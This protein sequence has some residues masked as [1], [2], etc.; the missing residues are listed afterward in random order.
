M[1]S[2]IKWFSTYLNN[3]PGRILILVVQ[4]TL[5]WPLYLMFNV[6]GRPYDRFACH[7]DPNSPIYTDHECLQIFVSDIGIFVVLYGLY[8][9]VAAKG[10]VGSLCLWM[11]ITHCQWIPRINHIVAAHTPFIA[12]LWLLRVGLVEGCSCHSWQRLSFLIRY[13]I[14]SQTLIWHTICSQP[15]HTIMQWKPQRL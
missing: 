1:K 14:T 13:S 15:C 8:S 3:P 12:S 2:S 7:F 9:L 5:G 4:L 11:S 10:L 6:S